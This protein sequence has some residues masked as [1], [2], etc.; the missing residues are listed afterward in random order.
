[1]KKLKKAGFI[2]RR[3]A[4]GSHE[5]WFHPKTQRSVTIPNYGGKDFKKGTLAS[6]IKDTGLSRK[7]FLSL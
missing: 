5:I 2:L 3:Q 4:A 7:A 1:M 6:M